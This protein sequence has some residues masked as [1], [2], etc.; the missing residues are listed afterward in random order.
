MERASLQITGWL[1]KHFSTERKMIFFAGPGNNGGDA[2]AIS[3]QLADLGYLCE[4]YLL[5]FGK[6]LKGSPAINWQRLKDQRKVK[7]SR[8]ESQNDF[9]KIEMEFLIIVRMFG[10]GLTRPLEGFAVQMVQ[11]INGLK[12]VAGAVIASVTKQSHWL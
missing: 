9:P 12:K 6:K 2:L 1:V 7:L 5:D 4:V 10:S 11:K 3:R 8:I